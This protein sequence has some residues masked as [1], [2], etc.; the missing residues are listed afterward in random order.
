MKV[1]EKAKQEQ[2][3]RNLLSTGRAEHSAHNG[4]L[5]DHGTF[6]TDTRDFGTGRAVHSIT[7]ALFCS[8]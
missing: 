8:M 4:D 5:P 2:R 7:R 1:M 3:A 6:T